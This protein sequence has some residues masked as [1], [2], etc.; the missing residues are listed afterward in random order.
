MSEP[1]IKQ[2]LFTADGIGDTPMKTGGE[3]H[4]MSN[5]EYVEVLQEKIAALLTEVKALRAK[6]KAADELEKALGFYAQQYVYARVRN[7]GSC[8]FS[9][10]EKDVGRTA[11]VALLAYNALKAASPKP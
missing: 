8:S 11:R 5:D 3:P 10:V 7:D 1:T 6:V 2:I 9:D 4:D